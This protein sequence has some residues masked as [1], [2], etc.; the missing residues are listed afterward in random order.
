M[1]GGNVTRGGKKTKG[2]IQGDP[3]TQTQRPSRSS[4]SSMTYQVQKRENLSSDTSERAGH[5]SKFQSLAKACHYCGRPCVINSEN[6]KSPNIQCVKC[7]KWVHK[8]C[9]T[10]NDQILE[11]LRERGTFLCSTCKPA[12]TNDEPSECSSADHGDI[13][14]GSTDSMDSDEILQAQ[15]DDILGP[16]LSQE[17]E[18]EMTNLENETHNRDIETKENLSHVNTDDHTLDPEENSQT[19]DPKTSTP[20]LGTGEQPKTNLASINQS[21]LVTGMMKNLSVDKDSSNNQDIRNHR[22]RALDSHALENMEQGSGNETIT[23][24]I[25]AITHTPPKIEKTQP[26][27]LFANKLEQMMLLIRDEIRD[28]KGDVNRIDNVVKDLSHQNNEFWE[29]STDKITAC[30]ET[31][32]EGSFVKLEENLKLNLDKEIGHKIEE[33]VVKKMDSKFEEKILGV[34]VDKLDSNLDEKVTEAVAKQ[35]DSRLEERINEKI[36]KRLDDTF[37]NFNIYDTVGGIVDSRVNC[38]LE[39]FNDRLW[40]RK[41]LLVANLPESSQSSIQNRKEEDLVNVSK[42]FN[43]FVTFSESDIESLPVRVGK[44][45]DKPRL[46]RVTFKSEHKLKELYF[47]ARDNPDTLN[48]SEKDNKKKLYLNR[49][50]SEYER[51]E[52]RLLRQNEIRKLEEQNEGNSLVNKMMRYNDQTQNAQITPNQGNKEASGTVTNVAGNTDPKT[53]DQMEID[54]SNNTSRPGQQDQPGAHYYNN[55]SELRKFQIYNN[56]QPGIRNRSGISFVRKNWVPN[57]R[58]PTVG[59]NQYTNRYYNEQYPEL[60]R[61]NGTRYE[62]SQYRQLSPGRSPMVKDN[63]QNVTGTSYR[64]DQRGDQNDRYNR[65]S[66]EDEDLYRN[67]YNRGQDQGYSHNPREF[68]HRG[69]YQGRGGYV[70]RGGYDRRGHRFNRR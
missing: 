49:D 50:Y 46:L 3:P 56:H 42:I 68:G 38:A 43:R 58:I 44:V 25:G 24:Q 33:A 9:E 35:V 23:E 11:E 22:F 64:Y 39:E 28:M 16:P 59:D 27:N 30:V 36:N 51:F 67:D 13:E 37:E 10:Q 21:N 15:F 26:E 5:G 54:N 34:V 7:K 52:R 41:N 63:F 20:I 6:G 12:E 48:P 61:Q 66:F 47:G 31:S 4:R 45:G 40:R 69:R 60:P 53:V 62:E 17:K 65:G 1:A 57:H 2:Q 32:M 70:R 29:A 55:Q 14:S 19:N 18:V 8:E